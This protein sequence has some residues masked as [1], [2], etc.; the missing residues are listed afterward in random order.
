M[1]IAVGDTA[2]GFTLTNSLDNQSVSLS[3]YAGKNVVLAFF[4]A[5][6]SGV[7]QSEMCAFRDSLA[8]FESLDAQVLGISIDPPFP[9]KAFA[10]QNNI[11]FPVL[12]DL[13]HENRSLG[14]LVPGNASKSLEFNPV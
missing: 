12:S 8:S 13:H 11:N 6:F 10:E 2:P 5:A 14:N 3:D 9:Q 4:P 1:A 7:C